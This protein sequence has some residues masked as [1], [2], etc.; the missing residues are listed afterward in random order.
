[1]QADKRA[2]YERRFTIA[3]TDWKL[4][5]RGR[6]LDKSDKPFSSPGTMPGVFKD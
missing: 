5:G 6:F 1:M 4:G 3:R 2:F